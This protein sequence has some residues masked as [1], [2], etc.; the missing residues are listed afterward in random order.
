M[1]KKYELP[2][3]DF[4]SDLVRY[5]FEVE[6]LRG[7]LGNGTTPA[8]TLT[9]L[10]ALFRLVMSV[11][12][13]RI[14]GNRTTVYDA[15]SELPPLGSAA[16]VESDALREITNILDGI[17]FIDA[18]DPTTPLSHIFVRELHRITVDGLRREGDSTPGEYRR[19]DVSIAQSAHTP[20][21]HVYVHAEMS[22]L[23][24]FVNRDMPTHQ[25][26]IHA[27]IAHHRFVWI[28]PF[29]NGN[30][31]VSRLFTYAMLR[32]NGFDSIPGYRAV[33]PT[34]V[35]GND[36]DGYYS[37]LEAADDLSPTGTI[38]WCEFF[39][40]GL[41][42]DLARL[43]QMQDF[44]FLTER[45]IDPAVD[46]LIASG[47]ATAAEGSALKLAARSGVV[48]AGDLEP[49]FSGSPSQRS[50][51]IRS[52]LERG[53]LVRDESG[54][55]FYRVSLARAPLGPYVIRQLDELGHLPRILRDDRR[56]RD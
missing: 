56:S 52:M 9:E 22:E 5:A 40:H 3:V 25:Q 43:I 18:T 49:A 32:R 31:R 35:F 48:K 51:A 19:R 53:L 46:R 34:A 50:L 41:R 33:N 36:R 21:S 20:P 13:A 45:L 29:G 42:D 38:G 2:P 47:G 12:S 4:G 14:E 28:H 30:G 8:R 1:N 37:A 44:T 24:D 11:V 10:H 7:D 54:P 6:R 27:A 16:P 55:R 26:M 15:L 17:D 39:V 23:L